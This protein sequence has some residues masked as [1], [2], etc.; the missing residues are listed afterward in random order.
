[1]KKSILALS[2]LALTTF[3]AA[4]L[5]PSTDVAALDRKVRI[6]NGTSYTMVAF[7]ASNVK[8][9]SWEEDMLGSRVLQPGMSVMANVDD[10]TGYCLYDFRAKFEGGREATKRQVNVCKIGTFTFN[11]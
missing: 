8:S 9:K 6:I 5:A 4:T 10:G 11:D 3:S 7:Q 2:V 1:M